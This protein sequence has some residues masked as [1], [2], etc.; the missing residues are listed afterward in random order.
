[1]VDLNGK[2]WKLSDL[3]KQTKSGVVSLTF[4]CSFCHSC[5][6]VEGR[7]DQ[8]AG[9]QKDRAT[10]LAVDASAGET[11]GGVKRFAARRGLGLPIYLDTPG[12]TSDLFGVLVTTTTVVI[13]AQGILRYR[14]QVADD[15]HRYAEEPLQSV[16][17]GEPVVVKETALQ[18]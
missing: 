6:G 4:W 10:V 2:R 9:A 16:L 15:Q 14:E 8:F 18:G 3:Q 17:A 1:M 5:R 7:L 11:V 13:D 12:K